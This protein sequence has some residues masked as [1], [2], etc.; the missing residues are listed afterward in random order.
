YFA[1][2]HVTGVIGD[3]LANPD[4]SYGD[5]F[6]DNMPS[7]VLAAYDL[8]HKLVAGTREWITR[9][10]DN[11]F[12][13]YAFAGNPARTF[14]GGTSTF[15]AP[16]GTGD[17]T[18]PSMTTRTPAP[19]K[20]GVS[21]T[22]NV[23]VTFS[24]SIYGYAAGLSLWRGTTKVSAV[25][26]YNAATRTVTLNPNSTLAAGV[27]YTVKASGAIGDAAGNRIRATKWTFRTA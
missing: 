15:T 3:L 27:T 10:A 14:N 13:T 7:D 2:H 5:I 16:T 19:S 12:W 1:G 25:V 22:A 23:V 9:E 18:A 6:W 26:T 24:E 11:P 20:T 21:R 4:K 17:F 8:P